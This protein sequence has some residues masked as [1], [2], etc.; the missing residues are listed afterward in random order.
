M[1]GIIL[2]NSINFLNAYFLVEEGT[3]N[4]KLDIILFLYSRGVGKSLFQCNRP[5]DTQA[6]GI[7]L[8]HVKAIVRD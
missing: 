6:M 1:F 2:K 4:K 7:C 8:H 3:N 5:K